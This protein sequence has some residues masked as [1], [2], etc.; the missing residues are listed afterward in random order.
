MDAYFEDEGQDSSDPLR[1]VQSTLDIAGWASE[2]D[3]DN[4]LHTSLPIRWGDC[5]ALFVW[6]DEPAALHFSVSLELKGTANRRAAVCEL[7]AMVNEQLWLGHFDFWTKERALM[8]RHTL[9]MFGRDGPTA[10]EVGSLAAA[11]MDAIERFLPAFNF[12]IWAGQ[13]PEEALRN[14]MMETSGEA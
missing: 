9:P 8:F 10:A 13:S 4:G 3:E 12:V 2:R 6:R 1:M 7:T 14:A 11:A 5:A